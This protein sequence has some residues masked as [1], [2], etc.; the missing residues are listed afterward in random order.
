MR[1]ASE[2]DFDASKRELRA[3]LFSALGRAELLATSPEVRREIAA[4]LD[5]A[6]RDAYP[7]AEIDVEPLARRRLA[8]D[9][10]CLVERLLEGRP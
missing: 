6:Q 5:R 7:H 10:A 2:Y 4:I 9:L 8:L 1:A 3:A